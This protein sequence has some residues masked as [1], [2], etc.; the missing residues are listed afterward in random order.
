MS[1]LP[2][3]QRD[4][5]VCWFRVYEN[6]YRSH[7]CVTFT[8]PSR[9]SIFFCFLSFV[10]NFWCRWLHQNMDRDEKK[11]ANFSWKNVFMLHYYREDYA[12][13]CVRLADDDFCSIQRSI[14]SSENGRSS[15]KRSNDDDD[16]VLHAGGIR[17]QDIHKDVEIIFYCDSISNRLWHCLQWFAKSIWRRE[18]I[19]NFV[20]RATKTGSNSYSTFCRIRLALVHIASGNQ[21]S[22]RTL[23]FCV[24]SIVI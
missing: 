13:T 18:L 7:S 20:T 9:W 23:T 16:T 14:C 2:N 22:I 6:V 19:N 24:H 17:P 21:C 8:A 12:P 4:A 5:H 10:E 11:M 15:F 3:A 1:F